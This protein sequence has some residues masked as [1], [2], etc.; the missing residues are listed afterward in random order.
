MVE[1]YHNDQQVFSLN[2]PSQA[3]EGRITEKSDWH[4]CLV[5][6]RV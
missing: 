2:F 1:Q 5:R 6:R 4:Y 3:A